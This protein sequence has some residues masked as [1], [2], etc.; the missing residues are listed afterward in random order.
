MIRTVFSFTY[1]CS[2]EVTPPIVSLLPAILPLEGLTPGFFF[3]S[4]NVTARVGLLRSF[5]DCVVH[6]EKYL[7]PRLFLTSYEPPE[8]Q[9]LWILQLD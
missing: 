5:F 6:P 9:E 4:L 8:D 1:S 7:P 3:E 2:N